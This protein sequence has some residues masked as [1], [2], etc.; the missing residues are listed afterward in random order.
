MV[1]FIRYEVPS[2]KNSDTEHLEPVRADVVGLELSLLQEDG[3][4]LCALEVVPMCARIRE[5]WH[6]TRTNDAADSWQSCQFGQCGVHR[7]PTGSGVS[8][9]GSV[10]LDP[11]RHDAR[12]AKAGTEVREVHKRS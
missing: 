3:A 9:P 12:R 7:R 6:A 8:R 5:E 4:W 11:H 2:A 10:R 1:V